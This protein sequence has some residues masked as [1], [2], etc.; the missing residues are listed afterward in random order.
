MNSLLFPYFIIA[1]L[2][3]VLN[4]SIAFIYSGF[5]KS[6]FILELDS[7]WFM[8]SLFIHY[9]LVSSRYWFIFMAY[10]TSL[11][12][13][14]FFLVT[15]SSGIFYFLGSLVLELLPER[16]P[17]LNPPKSYFF[18]VFSICFSILAWLIINVYCYFLNF[19]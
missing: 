11:I 6:L 3:L 13:S 9:F 8:K 5:E 19:S 16:K 17:F 14:G 12:S 2:G 1:Y 10:W 18:L 7:T 4:I 15:L